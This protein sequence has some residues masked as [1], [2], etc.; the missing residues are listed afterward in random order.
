MEIWKPVKGYEGLY[1]VSTDGRIRSLDRYVNYKGR[2]DK[3]RLVAG[4]MKKGT[5]NNHGYLKVTL[6]KDGKGKTRE[7][8]RIVA[9]TFIENPQNKKTVN[10]IDGVKTNNHLSNLE[11]ATQSEQIVHSVNVLGKG[12]KAV[13]QYDLSGNYIAT[14]RSIAEASRATGIKRC[15]ISNV[16]AGRRITTKKYKWKFAKESC[17]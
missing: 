10:H 11:W 1:E 12:I 5:L 6:F 9:E 17:L 14:Y 13:N 8:Q 7:I 3:F 16:I 2:K 4:Q 15:S